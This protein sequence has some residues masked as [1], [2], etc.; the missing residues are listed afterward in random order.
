MLRIVTAL[1]RALVLAAL[2]APAAGAQPINVSTGI[3]AGGAPLADGAADPF[4]TISVQG[5]AFNPAVVMFPV[6]QCCGMETVDASVAKWIT[7]QS[8]PGSASTGWGI[9]PVAV[10]QRTFDL[11]GYDLSSVSLTG[12]WRAADDLVGMFLNGNEIVGT[13]NSAWA[14]DHPLSVL[15]ASGF[16]VSGVNTIE[17]RA[18]SGNSTW[19]GFYM[20]AAVAGQQISAVPE[21]ASVALVATGAVVLLGAARR[22]R[23][24]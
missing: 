10:L 7:D 24:A 23:T 16:F 18:V 4:W 12:E 21:P 1:R 9:G 13:T 14:S 5:G 19:D 8:T 20:N 3:N 11:S 6:G 17:V 22:R 2:L 15:A